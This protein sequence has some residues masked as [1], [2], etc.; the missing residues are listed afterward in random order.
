MERFN[1]RFISASITP[2]MDILVLH[3]SGLESKV[4]ALA[5]TLREL[6]TKACMNPLQSME[7]YIDS[8]A[9]RAAVEGAAS[10]ALGWE[11]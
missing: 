3:T 5:A 10:K 7:G 11:F 4:P 9:F 8:A 6:V 1:E 2:S